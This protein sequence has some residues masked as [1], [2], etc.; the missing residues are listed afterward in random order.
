MDPAIIRGAL[1]TFRNSRQDNPGRYS[2]VEHQP[3][4][5]LLDDAHNPDGVIELCRV[6]RSYRESVQLT[7][8]CHLFSVA[9][10]GSH[11]HHIDLT[12]PHLAATFDAFVLSNDADE[13]AA[14]RDDASDRPA[15]E[16]LAWFREALLAQGAPESAITCLPAGSDDWRT[17]LHQAARI[18]SKRVKSGERLAILADPSVSRNA[19]RACGMIG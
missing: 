2:F 15:A 5:L 18:G 12:A 13:V 11:R 16:M 19:L 4:T 9:I 14:S 3:F 7:D 8:L 6:L 17:V 10:G 1:E